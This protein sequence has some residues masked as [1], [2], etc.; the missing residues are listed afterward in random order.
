MNK[1]IFFDMDGVLAE[2]KSVPPEKLNRRFFFLTRRPD[3]KMIRL[4]KNLTEKGEDVRI[5]SAVLNRYAEKE[6][7]IWLRIF[8]INPNR[9]TFVP[10]GEE[11]AKYVPI[12]K[13]ILIDDYSKN[14]HQWEDAGNVAVKYYNGVNGTNGTWKGKGIS[15]N[16]SVSQMETLI[17]AI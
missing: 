7:R 17:R 16:M 4:L 2:W 6:K 11:K 13:N 15:R 3:F 14:L 10:Y 5:L 9:A 8:G 12:G 1:I